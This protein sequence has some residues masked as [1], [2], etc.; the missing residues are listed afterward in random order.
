M[1][2]TVSVSA[3]RKVARKVEQPDVQ[4]LR[5]AVRTASLECVSAAYL[6]SDAGGAPPS[7]HERNW[8]G[9]SRLSRAVRMAIPVFLWELSRFIDTD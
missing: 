4:S 5:S 8:S 7:V 6:V 3:W 2:A 9:T 1:T